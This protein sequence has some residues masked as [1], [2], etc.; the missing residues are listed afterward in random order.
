MPG[1]ILGADP[2]PRLR[3]ALRGCRPDARLVVRVDE[4]EG[5]PADDLPGGIPDE[6][7]NR[8]A[9]IEH[10]ALRI[11]QRD[12]VRAVVEDGEEMFF[13]ILQQVQHPAVLERVAEGPFERRRGHLSLD[14]VVVSAGGHRIAI[15]AAVVVASQHDE[16]CRAAARP[17]RAQQVDAVVLAEAIVDQRDVVGAFEQPR[18]AP[19]VGLRPVE[20]DRAGRGLLEKGPREAEI[21]FIVVDQEDG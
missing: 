1:A 13:A 12:H 20:R 7:L 14:E 6:T 8:I 5:A 9:D 11:E 3:Q 4:L 15:D 21:I 18:E 19:L 16:R 2:I 17:S 10:R